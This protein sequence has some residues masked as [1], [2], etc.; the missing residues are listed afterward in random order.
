MDAS[1]RICRLYFDSP[2]G[3][4]K[5]NI[6][7]VSEKS[8][9]YFIDESKWDPSSDALGEVNIE[10]ATSGSGVPPETHDG[11]VGGSNI[12]SSNATGGAAG[13]NAM[14]GNAMGGNAHGGGATGGNI[15][16]VVNNK[17][18][19]GSSKITAANNGRYYYC[20]LF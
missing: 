7:Q 8:K 19:A 3:L 20:F 18:D 5:S 1:A 4:G 10:I 15:E 6:F 17:I 2:F 9:K 13:G 12:L 16:V 14:G 11:A